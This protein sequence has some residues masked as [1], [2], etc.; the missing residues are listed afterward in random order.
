MGYIS[1][2]TKLLLCQ[3]LQGKV[4]I[5]LTREEYIVRYLLKVYQCTKLITGAGLQGV[6]RFDSCFIYFL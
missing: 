5:K 4:R 1:G 6:R 2:S 3:V